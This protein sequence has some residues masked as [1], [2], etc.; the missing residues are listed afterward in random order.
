MD[1]F[2]NLSKK[3]I[4]SGRIQPSSRVPKRPTDNIT[5][6]NIAIAN[7]RPDVAKALLENGAN[8]NE[9]NAVGNTPLHLA[10]T[11]N[12]QD[13]VALLL[14][15]GANV[16]EKNTTGST[17]LHLANRVNS[18]NPE[19]SKLLL[20]KGADLTSTNRIGSTP[21]DVNPGLA[22]LN[23]EVQAELSRKQHY[24]VRKPLIQLS[25]GLDGPSTK[26]KSENARLRY[27]QDE[28]IVRDISSYLGDNTK[29]GK[30][31]RKTKKSRK[32]RKTK[33]KSR[34]SRKSR[35]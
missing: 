33:R 29:G 28:F 30:Y 12:N 17:P 18:Q 24:E 32:S 11:N 6:L 15:N 10:V 14:E 26:N 23:R 20:A 9:P 21:L 1:S 3:Q 2:M 13:M 4:P 16:N 25:E 31:K 19:I 5:T 7:N 22:E 27:L 35:K 8:V 34:K